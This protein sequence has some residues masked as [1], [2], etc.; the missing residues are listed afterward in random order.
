MSRRARWAARAR[1][2]R[3]EVNALALA[4]RD[5]R[6][7]WH[8][9]AFLALV[10]GYALSPLDLVPDVIPVLGQLDDLLLVPAGVALARRMVPAQVLAECRAR[11]EAAPLQ[12]RG[13]W[14]AAA[15]VVLA[16]ALAL[17][18]GI[19]WAWRLFS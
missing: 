18:L 1:A 5:P 13:A 4:F 7:P 3:R 19:W 6:T 8:T 12:W 15:A 17:A 14:W 10:V 11:A 9:K 2:L 16:W